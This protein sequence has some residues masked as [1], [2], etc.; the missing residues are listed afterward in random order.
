MLQNQLRDNSKTKKLSR[1]GREITQGRI[2]KV[3]F[4]RGSYIPFFE[5]GFRDQKKNILGHHEA[6]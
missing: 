1:G 2:L 4:R 3:K 6:R 5:S